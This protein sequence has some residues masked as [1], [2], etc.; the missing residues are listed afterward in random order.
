VLRRIHG[1]LLQ[2]TG[3]FHPEVIVFDVTH[4]CN[5]KCVGCD[6]RSPEPGEL[7]TEAWEDLA[8]QAARRGF[9]EL[10]VTGGEPLL[11]PD[12][13]ELLPRLAA[14][15][16]VSLNTNGLLLDRKH[17]LVAASVRRLYVSYDGADDDTYQAIRGV[18]GLAVLDRGIAKLR[19]RLYAHARVTIWEQNAEQLERIADRARDA[20]FT[21]LSFLAPD[22]TSAGFG[23]RHEM[24]GR[25]PRSDQLA[26]VER[27]LERLRRHPLLEQSDEA[28]DRV[29]HLVR[30]D[31]PRSPRCLAPWTSAVVGPTGTL[32]PCFFLAGTDPVGGDLAGA[33][34]RGAGFRRSLDTESNPT[35]QRCVCWRG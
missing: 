32:H 4:A 5:S 20:G 34:R 18:R 27:S 29:L 16:P 11:R 28:L 14:H 33:I 13:A 22:V 8:R 19:D 6:F 15:L 21:A 30:R 2:A 10:V 9:R 26:G 7:S 12:V 24:R 23:D 17:A 31:A 35:C 25:A 3:A 1:R